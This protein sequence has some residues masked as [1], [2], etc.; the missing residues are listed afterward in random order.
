MVRLLQ[1]GKTLLDDRGVTYED[2]NVED[3]QKTGPGDDPA[4]RPDGVPF[5]VITRDDGSK[6]GILGFDQAHLVGELGLDKLT[7]QKST[8]AQPHQKPPQ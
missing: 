8:A 5:T 3:N 1:S 7:D 6:V 2:V 4:L